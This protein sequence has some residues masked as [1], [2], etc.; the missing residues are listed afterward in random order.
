MVIFEEGDL[1]STCNSRNGDRTT[2]TFLDVENSV[3]VRL[4]EDCYLD[5]SADEGLE[6]TPAEE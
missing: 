1:C 2:V 3:D 4:C 5:F 6:L